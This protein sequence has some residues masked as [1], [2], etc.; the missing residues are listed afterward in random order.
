MALLWE[1]DTIAISPLAD[2]QYPTYGSSLWQYV[3][4]HANISGDGDVHTDMGGQLRHGI[5]RQ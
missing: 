1:T 4:P 2:S 5:E 3:F